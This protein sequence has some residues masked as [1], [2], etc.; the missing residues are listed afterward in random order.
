VFIET[1]VLSCLSVLL[2]HMGLETRPVLLKTNY[3]TLLE[4]ST[5]II[6][7][8]RDISGIKGVITIN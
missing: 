8:S 6:I 4:L 3:V 1:K 2:D 7:T 5:A